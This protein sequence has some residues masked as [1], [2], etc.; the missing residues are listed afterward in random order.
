MLGWEITDWVCSTQSVRAGD[1]AEDVTTVDTSKIRFKLVT[2][3][4]RL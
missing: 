4:M 3:G 1:H 2:S